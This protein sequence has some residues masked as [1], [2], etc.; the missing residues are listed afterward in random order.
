MTSVPFYLLSRFKQGS[1]V[2]RAYLS[3]SSIFHWN[4]TT[5][6][7]WATGKGGGG[8]SYPG[9]GSL[10]VVGTS[11]GLLEKREDSFEKKDDRAA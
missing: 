7:T 3:F 6:N 10:G 8:K 1:S 5:E 4:E 11:I 9:T 2:T